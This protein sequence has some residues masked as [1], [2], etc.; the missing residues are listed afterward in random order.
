MVKKQSPRSNRK[1]SP[2]KNKRK[3][4][5]VIRLARSDS[6]SLGFEYTE[7]WHWQL[8]HKSEIG[9]RF[10]RLMPLWL[11]TLLVLGG[12]LGIGALWLA[13]LPPA[14]NCQNLS[15]M[16]ADSEQM[17]CAQ[18]AAESGNLEQLL[19]AIAL[20]ESWQPSHPLYAEA[21]R[22]LKQWSEG[23][24]NIA[25][26]RVN[27]GDLEAGTRIANQIP[28]T[29]P[30][31]LEA[32]TAIAL[33]SSEWYK[34]EE[35]TTQ[36]ESA[37]AA[38]NWQLARIL[39]AELERFK[40]KYFNSTIDEQFRQRLRKEIE[41]I[42]KLDS[43]R[44]IAKV[45]TPQALEQAIAITAQIDSNTYVA[46]RGREEQN[47]WSRILL[48]IAAQKLENQDFTGVIQLA[49]KVRSD[50]P[51]FGEAQDWITLGQASQS[52]KSK[53][54]LGLFDAIA[55]INRISPDSRIYPVAQ[56]KASL[57][58][59]LL[60]DQLQLQFARTTA[61]I[62]HKLALELA[63]EQAAMIQIGRPQRVEA[64]TWIA[65]W[66]QQVQLLQDQSILATAKQVA[67]AGNLES[68]PAAVTA[69][70][71]V[72]LG[73][74]LRVEAQ[75]YIAQWNKQVQILEDRPLLDL[76]RDLAQ[77]GDL[78]AAIQTARKIGSDRVLYPEAEKEL[79]LWLAQKQTARDREI[80]T[81]AQSLAEQGF[82]ESAIT[83]ASEILP[84]SSLYP[85]AT[86]AI[87]T[88]RSQLK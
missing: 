76:A 15:P 59:S 10:R 52:A 48:Q 27:Q 42:E 62:G 47:R 35:I 79:R 84:D 6:A 20:V 12:S 19:A 50:S 30:I 32:Q 33:W 63:M 3:G 16:A 65:M 23:V 39:S 46:L 8:S 82:F 38:Q 74:P 75:T 69:A 64:Q 80:L 18:L 87:A 7:P 83:T 11:N 9:R 86:A 60:E 29:S 44:E 58:I 68:L 53:Q 66:R 54:M 41:A 55:S 22:L 81:L 25:L 71:Q 14:P 43:A 5:K 36:F 1:S 57:W 24:L 13:K 70:S 72:P 61:S 49:K 28:K 67:A 85:E 56:E 34:G 2:G 45:N 51:L 21:E 40:L 4:S 88:W 77:R 31:Y 78:V 37:L 17:Y 73:S 26:E